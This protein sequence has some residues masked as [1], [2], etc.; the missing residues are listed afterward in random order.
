M[1][2]LTSGDS[3]SNF[4]SN[5][6]YRPTLCLIVGPGR[7]SRRTF[8]WHRLVNA[9][10]LRYT[11]QSRCRIRD[12]IAQLFIEPELFRLHQYARIRYPNNAAVEIRFNGNVARQHQAD[13]RN[14]CECGARQP[15][16]YRRRGSCTV[17]SACLFH[18]EMHDRHR[19][20]VNTVTNP[21]SSSAFVTA[22]LASSY[23]RVYSD[24][25]TPALRLHS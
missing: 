6:A 7:N 12:D 3:P 25:K 23:G 16:G 17:E 19:S 10:R 15:A 22:S 11:H 20:W 4:A 1:G 8:D 13:F 24:F 14:D 21:S 5:S 9:E 18:R 2:A